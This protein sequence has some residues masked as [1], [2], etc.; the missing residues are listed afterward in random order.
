[1]NE[2][3]DDLTTAA[4][5]LPSATPQQAPSFTQVRRYLRTVEQREALGRFIA[6]G[7]TPAELAEYARSMYLASGQSKPTAVSYRFVIETGPDHERARA[8]LATMRAPGFI[9]PAFDRPEPKHYE[10]DDHDNPAHPAGVRE[11]VETLARG[12][13]AA[14]DDK[15]GRPRRGPDAPI[16][17]RTLKSCFRELYAN[18]A[19]GLRSHANLVGPARA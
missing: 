8:S 12:C 7:W 5:P 19:F 3:T 14:Y 9:M 4:S 1:L 11:A 13:M 15:K 18:N 16:S 17:K 6:A 10:W 2:Q